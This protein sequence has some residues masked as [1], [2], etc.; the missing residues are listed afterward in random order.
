MADIE[1]T[2]AWVEKAEDDWHWVLRIKAPDGTE[3]RFRLPAE[4]LPKFLGLVVNAYQHWLA[5]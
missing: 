5:A 4:K 1:A 3:Q 2:D